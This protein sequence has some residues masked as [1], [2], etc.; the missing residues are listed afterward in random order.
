[1]FVKLQ[2]N[3]SGREASVKMRKGPI[4]TMLNGQSRIYDKAGR[5]SCVATRGEMVL[6]GLFGLAAE[7]P[8]FAADKREKIARPMHN[9]KDEDLV[10]LYEIDDAVISE[11]HFPKVCAIELGNDAPDVGSLKKRL[12]GFNNAIDK[13]DGMEHG[14]HGRFFLSA[15][16]ESGPVPLPRP[17]G[18][19]PPAA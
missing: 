15:L 12:G 8:R 5:R 4:S 19:S 1:M 3:V 6:A 7:V 2:H 16:L 9:S 11:D 10:V 18:P 17:E 14:N 13:R